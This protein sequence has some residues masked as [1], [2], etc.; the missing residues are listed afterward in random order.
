MKKTILII[1]VIFLIYSSYTYI[2]FN[3]EAS[4]CKKFTENIEDCTAFA[5]PGDLVWSVEVQYKY[6]GSLQDIRSFVFYRISGFYREIE[7][8]IDTLP[9]EYLIEDT[10]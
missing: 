8:L 4:I 2:K 6:N 10:V 1:I 9:A 5:H 7:V 3:D